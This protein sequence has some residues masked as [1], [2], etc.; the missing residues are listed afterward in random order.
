MKARISVSISPY[1]KRK[2]MT[3]LELTLALTIVALVSVALVGGVGRWRASQQETSCLTN[4][5]Q[6]GLALNLYSA[7]HHFRLP[8]PLWRGQS[9]LY[10]SDATGE[11]DVESGN[12]VTLL[13]PYLD[14]PRVNPGQS[15]LAKILTCPAWEAH[16]AAADH[17]ICYYSAGEIL[18]GNE[19]EQTSIFPF[20]RAGGEPLAPMMVTALANPATT[21]AFWEFDRRIA[22]EGHYQTDPRVPNDP[23]HRKVRNVL[24]F[25]GHVE[26][27]ATF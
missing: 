18:V 22:M 2:A 3:L 1:A 7:E 9:P 8:G 24:F 4:L 13:G 6:I 19:D 21:P 17:P 20:G 27:R 5:R 23:V 12:L 25:D 10:Q 14:L 16:G 11:F 15:A 26:P